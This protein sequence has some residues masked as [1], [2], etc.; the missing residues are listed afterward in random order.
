MQ[1]KILDFD[2]NKW[3]E[4]RSVPEEGVLGHKGLLVFK[5]DI[6][7]LAERT[8]K[9]D[10]EAVRNFLK[11]SVEIMRMEIEKHKNL[12]RMQNGY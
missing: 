12:W 2:T 3:V 11:G 1:N 9:F 7:T 5:I 6:N 8:Y 4:I 10:E